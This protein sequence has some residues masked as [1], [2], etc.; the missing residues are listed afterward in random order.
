MINDTI[1]QLKARVGELSEWLSKEYA[2]IRTGRATPAILD[3]VMVESYGAKTPLKHVA[4]I[5]IEDAKTLR[6]MPWD[7][8][9]TKAIESGID[10]ANIGVKAVGDGNGLRLSFPDLTEERRKLLLKLTNEKLEEARI[11]LRKERERLLGLMTDAEKSGDISEDDKFRGKEELQ[12]AVNDG[13]ATLE[14]MA[15]KKET[16]ITS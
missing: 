14:A 8:S 15:K 13:N 4:A 2:G 10:S 16:E 11:S 12:K 5:N 1:K 9:L 6:I 3:S 7:N